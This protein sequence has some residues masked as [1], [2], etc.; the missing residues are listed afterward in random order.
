[1]G[2]MTALI[3]CFMRVCYVSI[4][5]VVINIAHLMDFRILFKFYC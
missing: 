5:Y 3:F 1:M 2:D 4:V